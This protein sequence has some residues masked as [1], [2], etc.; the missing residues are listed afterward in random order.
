MERIEISQM[1]QP[2]APVREAKA[3]PD[4]SKTDFARMLKE[5]D[6]SVREEGN[7]PKPEK[8][9]DSQVR[10]SV[11]DS[12]K[13]EEDSGTPK[14]KGEVQVTAEVMLQLQKVLSQ[15][16]EPHVQAPKDGGGQ[17]APPVQSGEAL[18]GVVLKDEPVLP[19]ALEGAAP[20][21][22]GKVPDLVLSGKVLEK[23]E[24][25]AEAV[26]P[27]EGGQA[28]MAQPLAETKKMAQVPRGEEHPAAKTLDQAPVTSRLET[29][30][31]SGKNE[32]DHGDGRHH[33]DKPAG[34]AA[35]L[36][37]AQNPGAHGLLRETPVKEPPQ[38]LRVKTTPE[39]FGNDL[40]KAIAPKLPGAGKSTTLSIELEPAAL[41][42]MTLKVIYEGDRATVSIMSAN[43]KT[44]E[45]LSRSAGEIAQIL[46]QKTGQQTVVY[47]P[48]QPGQ[49]LDGR[50][51]GQ[52]DDGRPDR[53]RENNK[54]QDRP[55]SFA[56]QLRL[57]LV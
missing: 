8:G 47:T 38:T 12:H 54:R 22:K 7:E 20:K 39:T 16:L 18:A 13:K 29:E 48:Q 42:K 36:H 17:E 52:G 14:D 19:K 26:V 53:D 23:A 9:D 44:L 4:G 15:L 2:P 27:R 10:E 37:S 3:G 28:V 33:D 51:G 55:D 24:V 49:N 11:K 56:Q 34:G 31:R 21:E 32:P 1:A 45:L 43:P 57:G 30:G 5:K 41:G 25:K 35:F 40:G 6:Q 50:Q 46:E